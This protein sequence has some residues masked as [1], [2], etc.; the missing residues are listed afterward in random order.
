MSNLSTLVGIIGGLAGIAIAVAVLLK[1]ISTGPSK[2]EVI[3]RSSIIGFVIVCIIA[4]SGFISTSTTIIVHNPSVPSLGSSS[5]TETPT[6]TPTPTPTTSSVTASSTPGFATVVP[7]SIHLQC[8]CTD[9]VRVTVTKIALLPDQTSMTW[10]LTLENVSPNNANIS[11]AQFYLQ[12][13]NPP[14]TNAQRFYATGTAVTDSV[15]LQ[16]SG[17]PNAIQTTTLIFNFMPY[18][19]SYTLT[20]ILQPCQGFCDSVRFAP[21]DVPF[22]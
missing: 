10:T 7:S 20:S 1:Y 11:F 12:Q 18:A 6:L 22:T 4:L 5:V 16:P 15:P 19:I 8:N 2:R 14:T 3:I 9:P 17:Q 21:A 13:G